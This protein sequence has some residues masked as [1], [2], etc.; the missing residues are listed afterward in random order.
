MQCW[1]KSHYN[2]KYYFMSKLLVGLTAGIIVGMLFA[3]DKGSATRQKIADT[4]KDLKTKF[5]D[6]I[7]GL[8]SS[9]DDMAEEAGNFANKAKA[10][11]S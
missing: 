5:N 1:Y 4:G 2:P 9:A 11:F 10:Q 8:S 3:P 6:F 7:D